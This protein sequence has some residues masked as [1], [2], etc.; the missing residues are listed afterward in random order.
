MPDPARPNPFPGLRPYTAEQADMFFGR[1]AQIAEL[2]RKLELHR[3]IAVVGRSGD[4]K[5]SLVKAGLIP[6]LAQEAGTE[7]APVWT[8]EEM[9]PQGAPIAQL[10]ACLDRVIV[11]AH[12]AM[13]DI[14]AE[15]RLDRIRAALYRSSRGISKLMTPALGGRRLFLLVD[16]FEEL[17]RFDRRDAH[18]EDFEQAATFV[19]LILTAARQPS[20]PIH[21]VLTMRSDFL[22][23][24][25][26]FRNLPEA[27]NDSQFLVPRLTRNERREAI[28]GPIEASGGTVE[29]ALVQRLLNDAGDAPDM[30]PVLQHAMMRTWESAVER[31]EGGPL[32]LTL[33][34]YEGAGQMRKALSGHADSIYARLDAVEQTAA[35]KLFKALIDVD[36]EGR[37]VRRSPAPRLSELARV[38]GADIAMLTHIVDAFRAP[39]NCMLM[40][41]ASQALTPDTII[42]ISHEAIIRR[43]DRVA[44]WVEEEERDARIWRSLVDSVGT[45]AT[46]LPEETAKA[47][48]RWWAD[49]H[50]S[51]V[52]AERY[53]G[54]YKR[55]SE[56][57]D[58]SMA[59]VKRQRRRKWYQWATL[60][61]ATVATLAT[62]YIEQQR[63]VQEAEADY[64]QQAEQLAR[65]AQLLAEENAKEEIRLRA[66]AE[67]ARRAAE[68]AEQ[69]AL[70]FAL[71]EGELR[72]AAEEARRIAEESLKREG[73]ARLAAEQ[74]LE[75]ERK[76]IAEREEAEKLAR[77]ETA[78][79]LAS[80]MRDLT[81]TGDTR[82][83]LQLARALFEPDAPYPILPETEAAIYG[84]LSTPYWHT[85]VPD[86]P[87]AMTRTTEALD[88]LPE[89]TISAHFLPGSR[90]IVASYGDA[91][92][93]VLDGTT[94]EEL[95]RF[96]LGSGL[97]AVADV[98]NDGSRML[99]VS[100][101][102]SARI[103]DLQS[104]KVLVTL[105]ASDGLS[106]NSTFS[107]DGSRVLLA[108]ENG[109]RLYDAET[110][111]E[112]MDVTSE[113]GWVLDVDIS[114]SGQYLAMA[115]EAS[116]VV[117]LDIDTGEE[118]ILEAHD[119]WVG[120]VAFSPDGTRL[121]TASQD[122]GQLIVWDWASG[123]VALR[124]E[125]GDI[126]VSTLAYS[127]DGRHLAG[128]SNDGEFA[129][130][131]A[132]TGK[133]VFEDVLWTEGGR[134]YDSRL[135]FSDD[136]ILMAASPWEI[137]LWDPESGEVVGE[138]RPA[139]QPV[140][141]AAIVDGG[142]EIVMVAEDGTVTLTSLDFGTPIIGGGAVGPREAPRSFAVRKNTSGIHALLGYA[143]GTIRISEGLEDGIAAFRRQVRQVE[144]PVTALAVT[145]DGKRLIAGYES[146]ELSTVQLDGKD[147][148]AQ[149]VVQLGWEGVTALELDAFGSFF[150]SGRSN[151]DVLNHDIERVFRPPEDT[152][153]AESTYVFQQG[154]GSPVTAIATSPD[155]LSVTV[156]D[157]EGSVTWQSNSEVGSA[158]AAEF[159]ESPVERMIYS[160]DG[161]HRAMASQD[162]GVV[163]ID[164]QFNVHTAVPPGANEVVALAFGEAMTELL[165]VDREHR[166]TR[167][168]A[169]PEIAG[170]FAISGKGAVSWMPET[171]GQ[172]QPVEKGAEW[173]AE[174]ESYRI[175]LENTRGGDRLSL[176][177]KSSGDVAATLQMG[178]GTT[179]ASSEAVGLVAESPDGSLVAIDGS[180]WISIWRMPEEAGRALTSPIARI[181]YD[182]PT[183][184]IAFS[185]DGTSL[186]VSHGS[187]VRV[188]PVFATARD[189]DARLDRLNLSELDDIERC[190]LRLLSEIEC[191]R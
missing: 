51:E 39:G 108:T 87:E 36:E 91:T 142:D 102:G 89:M 80:R 72:V 53:G 148:A 126:E 74:A 58:S 161:R 139:P 124:P 154:G 86:G 141:D 178:L 166:L 157:A 69:Q 13:A 54:K 128:A 65:E 45:G 115:T 165:V 187:S 186:A 160:P 93:R 24:C 98:S 117:I 16:Q 77:S 20:P 1:D 71:K 10:A 79:Y 137:S 29:P 107:L 19:D 70:E 100:Q 90:D 151:G 44:E 138:I 172:R 101:P 103:Q 60:V 97:S 42:D 175:V 136:G 116:A 8:I 17:F 159:L 155:G 55:I 110:G 123:N 48:L 111:E 181:P 11:G 169:Q 63:R 164:D 120:S 30:L 173:S 49:V 104:G 12:G 38:T 179:I 105:G 122:D 163:V 57:L 33:G 184:G 106:L 9:R 21:V 118:D 130:W 183:Q 64:A 177:W 34:D 47:R 190:E 176:R 158:M 68:G 84:A 27:I 32:E 14:P 185:P 167:V 182:Q 112:V 191:L 150:Y 78:R 41:E 152:D 37:V 121:A 170:E 76:A 180:S 127:P 62:V 61:V 153:P 40:P 59:A 6:I 43:W 156:A 67:K 82:Q 131:E 188:W 26:R 15:A 88:L 50:P 189:L 96:D 143:D 2:R 23:D 31:C 25:P 125:Q 162:G 113:L 73:E 52:W 132:A 145:D 66:E 92:I 85:A 94:G 135:D 4:G 144:S 147:L 133:L 99:V 174:T 171:Y 149:S 56:L 18:P 134:G 119:G 35:R 140:L 75:A 146:G 5:S 114:P 95:R 81:A 7:G 22:G 168:R 129:V 28:V 3:F 109:Q 83:A 46:E